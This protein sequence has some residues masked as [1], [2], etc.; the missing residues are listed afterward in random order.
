VAPMVGRI[1]PT[2][3]GANN[4]KVKKM[5]PLPENMLGREREAYELGKSERDTEWKNV[6][7]EI[8]N[9]ILEFNHELADEMKLITIIENAIN[10]KYM[11]I[12]DRIF[13]E[14]MQK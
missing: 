2:R 4:N 8:K 9:A 11:N 6:I 10:D 3:Q 14:M 13:E 1:L 5:V 7:G 12:I